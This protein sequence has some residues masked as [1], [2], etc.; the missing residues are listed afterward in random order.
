MT[1]NY[2]RY[3]GDASRAADSILGAY[4][5]GAANCLFEMFYEI[6]GYRPCTGCP[7]YKGG[8]CRCNERET[9][10]GWL[11]SEAAE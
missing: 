7:Y 11:E 4:R 1:T 8:G 10:V 5:H 3:F 9:V 2:E 6:F